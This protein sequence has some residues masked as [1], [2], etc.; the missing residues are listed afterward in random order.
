MADPG[1]R[2]KRAAEEQVES[3]PEGLQ[4]WTVAKIMQPRPIAVPENET[5]L[6]VCETMA[7]GRVGQVLV[8]D[9]DWRP[10]A[11]LDL[12][13]EP[14]G[15]FTERDL[16]R[17]FATHR[18]DVLGMKVSEVMTTPVVTVGPDDDLQDVADMMM[19]MQI[20]RIPV[21]ER[22]RTV[23]ILT[24]GRVMEAQAERMKQVEKERSALEERVVHD[25]LT[26]L[27]NRVLF[28]KVLGRELKRVLEAGGSVAV[29]M[30]DIDHFKK[31]NDTYGHP[32]GD[33]VLRQLAK[34]MRDTLR[35]ADLPARLG[36]E[37]FGVVLSHAEGEPKEA[38]EKLR[39]AVEQTLF[40]DPSEPLRVTVSIGV[41]TAAGAE[42]D[43]GVLVKRADSAL[44]EAK[45]K[46]RNRVVLA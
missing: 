35:R 21:V 15:I 3:R 25:P 27:A 6:M 18:E 43:A 37:E 1:P 4:G 17:A 29:L 13:P 2:P 26:G 32:V 19:L 16:I 41:A 40:G 5:V 34:V 36:G 11:R 46:G 39:L 12:P 14:K 23:G 20:R 22:Q 42:A 28:E 30:L 45:S 9:K 33:I 38:A 44:Y 10:R 31:V 8:V 7:S 24:R